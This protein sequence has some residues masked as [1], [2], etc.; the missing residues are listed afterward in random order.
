LLVRRVYDTHSGGSLDRLELVS[1]KR[2]LVHPTFNFLFKDLQVPPRSEIDDL[3]NDSR[4]PG[5]FATRSI[6]PPCKAEHAKLRWGRV[7][8]IT[9][10]KWLPWQASYASWKFPFLNTAHA[11]SSFS[12]HCEE[13]PSSAV[14]DAVISRGQR[15]APLLQWG[16]FLMIPFSGPPTFSSPLSPLYSS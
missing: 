3:A 2:L 5:H 1:A 6:Q 11:Q 7:G 10:P 13:L 4:A 15:W 9:S 14:A 12:L 16:Q 8:P